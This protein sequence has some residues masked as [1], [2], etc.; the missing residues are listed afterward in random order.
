MPVFL[1]IAN[2]IATA[3]LDVAVDAASKLGQAGIVVIL[4]FIVIAL[5]LAIRSLFSA[6]QANTTAVIEALTENTKA[7]ESHTRALEANERASVANRSAIAELKL[8]LR[9]DTVKEAGV[10][11]W[12]FWRTFKE[13]AA[14]VNTAKEKNVEAAEQHERAI[15]NLQSE[16]SAA[17]DQHEELRLAVREAI[18]RLNRGRRNNAT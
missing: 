9:N 6:H 10:V 15:N 7:L 8:L 12:A 5:G 11:R 1:L 3:Q 4:L 18:R 13:Q 2:P 14:E 16:R 17:S